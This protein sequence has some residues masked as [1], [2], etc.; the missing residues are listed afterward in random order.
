MPS[1]SPS[2]AY[3]Y[4]PPSVL[5]LVCVFALTACSWWGGE[6]D[7]AILEPTAISPDTLVTCEDSGD[8]AEPGSL[9]WSLPLEGAYAMYTFSGDAA[10]MLPEDQA[11]FGEY[12]YPGAVAH[13]GVLY[14]FEHERVRAVDLDTFALLWTEEVDPGQAKRVATLQPVGDR[15]LMLAQH[16]RGR[17]GLVYFLDP[18]ADGLE[19]EVPDFVSDAEWT[20]GLPANDTH[21]LVP[22][23]GQAR[24]HHYIEVA[25]GQVEW[26]AELPGRLA[27]TA[28]AGDT[29]FTLERADEDDDEPDLIRRVDLSDGRVV[30]EIPVPEE[31]YPQGRPTLVVSP[32]GGVLMGT[33]GAL[34]TGTGELLWTHPEGRLGEEAAVD[35]AGRFDEDDPALLH[36]Q[37]GGETWVLEA[38]TGELVEEDAPDPRPEAFGGEQLWYSDGFDRSG[39]DRYRAPV[40][41]RGPGVEDGLVIEFGAGSRHLTTYRAD[42]GAYVG[43]YQ[44][45]APDGMRS[46][47]WDRATV[48]R[49]CVA[50]RLFAVDYGVDGSEPQ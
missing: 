23:D 35:G 40:Q 21:V 10:V 20:R 14:Y 43:V 28:V 8:C 29:A 3:R 15:L 18:G 41:A 44:G 13:D 6:S 9:R 2:P 12:H 5:G 27:P 19:W 22:E 26:S 45:C 49:A 25:T 30:D 42:D 37:D 1:A 7:P 38:R 50:P 32:D 46:A 11:V 16:G 47:G 24:V 34:D 4:R 48:Y 33:R 39:S 17:Q 31:L 36:V